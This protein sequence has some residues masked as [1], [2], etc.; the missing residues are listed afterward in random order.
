MQPG[1]IIVSNRLPVSVKRVDGRLE[2]YP[3]VG[4][5]ATGLSSYANNKKNKWIGWPGIASDDLSEQDRVNITHELKKHNCYPVFLTQKQL[6]DFYSGFSNS[7]LWPALHELDYSSDTPDKWWEAYKRV[8]MVF[9]EATLGHSA[10]GS[11]I[12]VHDYQLLL[13]PGLLRSRRADDTIGFFLHIPFPTPE[14]FLAIPHAQRLMSELLGG[15][16]IGF[17]TDSYVQ[18]FLETCRAIGIGIPRE[19]KV[20]LPDRVVRVT[21]FPMGIDYGKFARATKQWAVRAEHLKFRIKYRGLRVILTVDRLDPT[22]GLVERLQAYRTLLK[23]QPQLHGKVIMVMLAV[24]SRTEIPEYQALRRRLEKLV[25]SVNKEF[26]TLRWQPV[27]YMYK[28]MPFHQLTALYRRADIAFI[29]PIKD[30]MNLVAKEYLATQPHR[31]GVLILSETAGAADELKDAIL[32]NPHQKHSLVAG[33][34]KAL[35]T[36]PKELRHQAHRMQSHLANATVHDW[37]SKFMQ[38]LKESHPPSQRGPFTWQLTQPRQ[39][40]VAKAYRQAHERVVLLDYDGVLVPFRGKPGDAAPSPSLLTKLN[41]L[42]NQPQTHVAI[43][44]GR[45]KADLQAWFGDA[46]SLTLIAEH[47]AFIRKQG[48]KHWRANGSTA[49][50]G[51][52]QEALELLEA[53]DAKTPGAHV[54]EKESALVWHYRR[55]NQYYAHKHLVVLKRLLWRLAKKYPIVIEQGNMILEIRLSGVHKG[56]AALELLTDATDFVLAIGDDATDE[57]MFEHLPTWAH[58]VKVGRGRTKARYRL[59][60]VDTVHDLLNKLAKS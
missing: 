19:H 7:I 46:P 56:S 23:T 52:K 17:H 33:L 5:L 10:H 51:W 20:I 26:G 38:S 12:W 24:P 42:G 36:P 34:T 57:D 29:A 14:T 15:D 18:N 27:D 35:T 25:K 43:I 1:I 58:T 16:L 32:V 53:Y 60:N 48:A 3:S 6:D 30:G 44:S 21:D 41:K 22:K 40:E 4:G 50:M 59:K 31:R 55:G 9:A 8:N 28:S 45:P 39:R 13:L 47:G 54:E 2:Y 11:I 37:A 49:D